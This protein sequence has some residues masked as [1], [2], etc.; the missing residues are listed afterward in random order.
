[1]PLQE[2]SARTLRH[3]RR[4]ELNGY[5]REDGLWDIE[6]HLVDTKGYE[7][8]NHFRGQI[9]SGEPVHDMWLRLTLDD[10]LT[11][12]AVAACTDY[13]PF[14]SCPQ[15]APSYEQLVGMRIRSGWTETVRKTMGSA[16]SCTHLYELL[17][18]LATVAMQTIIPLRQRRKTSEPKQR[19]LLL[20]TCYGWRTDGE[21]VRE[22][23]PDWYQPL[24]E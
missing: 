4:I 22:L 2:A 18:P 9:P 21:V 10:T 23:Y 14:P 3:T 16:R 1:M 20:N 19:P 6:A 5:E 12:R 8:N 11:I 13:S 24:A 17:R 15:A 7:F